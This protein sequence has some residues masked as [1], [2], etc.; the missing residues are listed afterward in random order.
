MMKL[1]SRPVLLLLGVVAASSVLLFS[2]WSEASTGGNGHYLDESSRKTTLLVASRNL[3]SE[4]HHG[5]RLLP[6]LATAKAPS[7]ASLKILL[8]KST[9]R[10]I[11]RTKTRQEGPHSARVRSVN[12]VK[13]SGYIVV[14]SFREQQTK[15]SDNLFG[16]QCWANTLSV[17]IV[18]PFIQNSHFVVPMGSDRSDLLRFRDIFDLDVWRLLTAQHKFAP[19]ASW[20]N[21]L[22]DAPRQL[23]V[24]RFKYLTAKMS[25]RRKNSNESVTHLAVN[26]SYKLGCDVY[27]ELTRKIQF[28]TTEH[29]FTIVR[30]VCFNFALGDEL[31]LHQFNRHLFGELSPNAVTVLMEEWRGL[32]SFDNGKRVILYD[33][34]PPSDY[35]QSITY[36]W[37][38]QQLICDAKKY[39][40]KYLKTADY[41]SLM[42]RTEKI[43]SLNPSREFMTYCLNE[44]LKAWRELVSS[45]GMKTTFLAM[46]IGMYGSDSLD[47]NGKSKY[48]PFLDLY[49]AFI[50]E[51]FG[52]HATIKM[53]E[54][55][56]EA[57]AQRQDLGYIGSLQKTLSAESKCIVLAGG[58][59]FQKHAQHIYERINHNRK[60]KPCLKVLHKCSRGLL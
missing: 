51:L 27:A 13:R 6:K 8:Q 2:S 5:K 44:T 16:L 20:N 59:T 55:G 58:G 39:R 26:N 41:I 31:T 11:C 12:N 54:L 53:W 10:L 9:S 56:F 37:P 50:Q 19:L 33:A 36:T 23:I 49:K 46:D 15:A 60:R 25:K 57:T 21:F 52:P 4:D 48:L 3:M 30:E 32:A 18:E 14:A 35:V 29:N 17:N 43:L 45:T 38:S 28:L 24:V 40:Q 47:Q 22:S 7:Q 42:V 34:C 1:A